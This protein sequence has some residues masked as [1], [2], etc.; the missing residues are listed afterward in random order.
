MIQK[1]KYDI[2]IIL[3]VLGAGV[4]LFLAV[5]HYLG[6]AVPCDV[7]HGCEAVLNSK[8]STFIGLPLSVWGVGYFV[9]VIVAALLANHYEVWRKILTFMLSVGALAALVFLS[10]QFFVIKKVCQYCLATD[11]LSIILLILDINIEHK[12]R[13]NSLS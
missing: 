3:A 2:L 7:T 8:Y 4:S 13:Q 11:V 5:S 6:F 10:L 12:N 9:S 1:H